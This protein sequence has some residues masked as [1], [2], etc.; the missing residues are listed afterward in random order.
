M[1]LSTPSAAAPANLWDD[2]DAEATDEIFAEINITPLTDVI[3]VLLIIFMVS[4]TAMVDAAREQ[5][6][7]VALPSAGG[8]AQAG[9]Q[10]TTFVVGVGTDGRPFVQGQFVSEA[11]LQRLLRQTYQKNPR[12][13]VIVDADG[14]LA[15]RHVVAIIDKVRAAGFL[16]VGIGAQNLAAP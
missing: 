14:G 11:D 10:D 9:Q 12:T 7:E 8:A 1:G 5:K 15:H 3:L 2:A 16:T 13:V 4:S 6:L